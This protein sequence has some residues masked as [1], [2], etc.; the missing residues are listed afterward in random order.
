M[1]ALAPLPDKVTLSVGFLAGG[2]G[3]VGLGFKWAKS[4]VQLG[5][6]AVDCEWEIRGSLDND[7]NRNREFE[8]LVGAPAHTVDLFTRRDYIAF[9]GEFADIEDPT[10]PFVLNALAKKGVGPDGVLEYSGRT[11][12]RYEGAWAEVIKWS[13]P[14]EGWEEVTPDDMRRYFGEDAPDCIFAS[15]PCQGNSRL[16]SE[17]KAA[18]WRYIALNNL[19]ERAFYLVAMAWPDTPVKVQ[20]YENVPGIKYRSKGQLDR[21]KRDAERLGWGVQDG[22][23]DAGKVGGCAQSRPRW[24]RAQRNMRACPPFLYKPLEQPLKAIKDVLW[25]KPMPGDPQGGAMHTL[26][27]LDFITWLR[28]ALI[29]P[30]GDWKD[31]PG[32]GEW[33]LRTLDGRI[34]PPEAFTKVVTGKDG[35]TKTKWFAPD[36][37]VWGRVWIPELLPNA[38]HYPDVRIRHNPMGA[39]HG[40]YWVQDP[41]KHTSTVTGDV[42]PTKTGS[43]SAVSDDRIDVRCPDKEN[44]HASHLRVTAEN[45]AAGT[46]TGATHLA[47]GA[48][49]CADARLTL[50]KDPFPNSYGVRDGE[51][52]IGTITAGHSPSF[53][54]NQVSDDRLNLLQAHMNEKS[55]GCKYSITDPNHPTGTVTGTRFG[56]GAPGMADARVGLETPKFN[57]AFRLRPPE[58]NAGTVASGTGPSSG[59]TCTADARLA[60][61]DKRHSVKYKVQPDDGSAQCITTQ[62]DVQT[63]APCTADARLGFAP[64]DNAYAVT[65][66]ERESPAIPGN[67]SVTSSNGPGAV[68][69]PRILRQA[70]GGTMSVHGPDDA[71]NTITTHTDSNGDAQ[72]LADARMTCACRNGTLGVVTWTGPSPAVIASLDVYAGQAAIEDVRVNIHWWPDWFPDYLIISPWNAWHRPLTDW[73]L[74]ILQGFPPYDDEGRAWE[75]SGSRADRRKAIGNAV[76]P[77]AAKA[78]AE[79]LAPTLVV[80]KLMP[81]AFLLSPTGGGIWVQED[82]PQPQQAPLWQGV[83]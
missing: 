76:P 27:N 79:A 68:A 64:R 16:L 62:V 29:P 35:K 49:A 52:P 60:F 37:A 20:L 82:Q 15:M 77:P 58:E 21:T 17:A 12:W 59:G 71:A 66:S 75:I 80:A 24:F 61:S 63:G 51:K 38:A 47:N 48:Q 45:E 40:A 1:D 32:P 36:T 53:C 81:E 2:L 23:H 39:T 78:Y 43:A 28:L 67:C 31:I 5:D 54:G 69:D 33:L 9:H 10:L 70:K 56:S 55:H 46:A 14:P 50:S 19:H 42:R 30:G 11:F 83:G 8:R 34:I 7:L 18:T 22:D 57:E 65:D 73:E 25:D 74:W 13:P 3:G 6:H 44:R 72:H 4:K 26:P 41:A